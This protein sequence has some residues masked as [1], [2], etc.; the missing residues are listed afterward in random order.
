MNNSQP[1]TTR[2]EISMDRQ[3]LDVF[4]DGICKR[5]F[6]V[7]T[8][9]K[10]MGFTEGSLRTPTGR[11]V[12]SEKI[13]GDQ[14]IYTK[15]V[16]REPVGTWN[17]EEITGD[18]LI[19]TRILRLDGLDEENANTMDRYV[20]IHGTNREDLIGRPASHGCIR[21]ANEDMI[22]LFDLVTPMSEVQVMPLTKKRGRILFIDCDSTLSSI[23][24][25]DELA[26]LSDPAIF[27]EVVNLTNAAMNG[28]VPLNDVFKKRMDIIKPSKSMVDKVSQCYLETMV[29][30]VES[31]ISRV[32]EAGWLPVIISGGFAPIIK[33]LADHLGI[34]H[35]EA[36]PLNFNE[37][38]EY[39]G[40][41]EDYPTTR[42][43]G[44]N[45]II[46]DWKKALLPERVVMI[47]DGISDL[48][49]KPDV[50][51]MVGFG[52]VVQ[53]GKVKEGADI[54]IEDFNT[55]EDL[56]DLIK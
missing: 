38:G 42:N 51:L 8:S 47:G 49:T 55:Q 54:W 19:L 23:E 15:F 1:H 10:G 45:E 5:S 28:E 12:I 33:P 27:A 4:V 24:G 41:G 17:P 20:Y 36:V 37:L 34:R 3:T 25:I 22:E 43:L 18:D 48:E 44:K 16:A 46:R 2:L 29:P 39:C 26:R 13:G 9:E 32:I 31:M 7:S 21:L 56:T 35:V 11:F 6:S 30:G 50:D 14:P 40:Y 52:G 53:R